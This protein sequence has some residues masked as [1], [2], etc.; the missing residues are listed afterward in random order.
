VHEF[1]RYQITVHYA[2]DPVHMKRSWSTTSFGLVRPPESHSV[3]CQ[4]CVR[5]PLKL[6]SNT[7]VYGATPMH[8]VVAGSR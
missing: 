3:L 1:L 6:R 5:Y 7:V 4:N 8:I 2:G